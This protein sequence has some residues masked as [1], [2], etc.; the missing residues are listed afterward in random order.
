MGIKKY[1]VG[2]MTKNGKQYDFS[3]YNRIFENFGGIK[4]SINKELERLRNIDDFGDVFMA[5]GGKFLKADKD[6]CVAE[7]YI[8]EMR[9]NTLMIKYKVYELI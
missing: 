7:Y 2:V 8:Q 5:F 3:I 1:I 9:T 6:G 4:N